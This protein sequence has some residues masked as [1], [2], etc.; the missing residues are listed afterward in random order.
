MQNKINISPTPKQSKMMQKV[1]E[2]HQSGHLDLAETYYKKLLNDLP[3]NTV[4]LT[5]F[6]NSI[7]FISRF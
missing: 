2:M 1:L 4:L 7:R 5:N 6:G 3:E